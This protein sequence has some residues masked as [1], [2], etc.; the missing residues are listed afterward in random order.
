MCWITVKW[1]PLATPEYS[2][3]STKIEMIRRPF[4]FVDGP[5][6][7]HVMLHFNG[8]ELTRIQSLEKKGDMGYLR[9]E[10]KMLGMLEKSNDEQR[11]FQTQS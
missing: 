6:D 4:E 8:N 7:R 9:V 3:S 1:I 11:L 5:A 2:S 10:P